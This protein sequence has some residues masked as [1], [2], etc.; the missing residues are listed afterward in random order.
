MNF[1]K[2][3][4]MEK[5]NRRSLSG[6]YIFYKFEDEQKREPTAFEDCPE[7]KQ[8]EWMSSLNREAL[9]NLAKQLARSLR[10]VGDKFDITTE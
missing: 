6:I 4:F 7:Q 5:I 10:S 9:I 8:D 2:N 3:N 1:N